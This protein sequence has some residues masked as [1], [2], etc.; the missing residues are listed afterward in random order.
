MQFS[1]KILTWV[2]TGLG[3][4]VLPQGGVVQGLLQPLN[5][6]VTSIC[7]LKPLQGFPQKRLEVIQETN[8]GTWIHDKIIILSARESR[9]L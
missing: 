5:T 2:F 9:C 1:I 4:N 8:S 7:L 6:F 3:V